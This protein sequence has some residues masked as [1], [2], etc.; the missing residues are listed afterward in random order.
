MANSFTL[1]TRPT[2]G[3]E[4]KPTKLV[5]DQLLT[6]AAILAR[7]FVDDPMFEFIFPRRDMRLQA[8]TAFFRPFVADGLQRGEVLLAP[9]EQGACVWYASQVP[10]FSDAF[11]AVVEE[12]IATTAHF[13]GP[14]AAA[15]L[16]HLVNQVSAYEPTVPRYEVLWIG[17][18]PE[19]RS[20]GLGGHL[21]QPV[22]AAADR[23]RAASYLV[24]SNRRNLSFYQR[25]GFRPTAA[26]EISPSYTMTGMG[27]RLEQ[28]SQ[29][30]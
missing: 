30:T 1:T 22:L 20:R 19:A 14:D 13:G 16:E 23:Q 4:G 26:I 28:S 18:V 17:L 9:A 12:A 15:R 8:L 11:E 6:A 2:P 21:L 24:S 27:R 25:H 5:P 29:A 10:L 7:S 3:V